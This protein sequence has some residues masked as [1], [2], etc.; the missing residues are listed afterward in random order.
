MSELL[1]CP[2]CC[3]TNLSRNHDDGLSWIKCHGCGATGPETTKYSGDDGE[4]VTDWNSRV[5]SVQAEPTAW[6]VTRERDRTF[7]QAFASKTTAE[8]VAAGVSLPPYCEVVPLY[9]IPAPGQVMTRGDFAA[10]TAWAGEFE[11]GWP[12]H[13]E[14]ACKQIARLIRTALQASQ[15]ASVGEDAVERV[16]R[17]LCELEH[18]ATVLWEHL[19]ADDHE[20]Y[21][22]EARE[23]IQAARMPAPVVEGWSIKEVGDRLV[24]QSSIGGYAADGNDENNIA[25]F[26]LYHFAAAVL[27]ASPRATGETG[28]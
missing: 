13:T 20:Q 26:V 11:R 19:E 17:K 9:A 8:I 16:A 10:L 21:R 23:V 12:V 7:P 1:P 22:D 27:A 3:G 14:A 24:V 15:T 25:S 5:A 6:L 28:K 18:G 2:F 4:P